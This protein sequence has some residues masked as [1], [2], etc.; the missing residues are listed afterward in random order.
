M[1]EGGSELAALVR[2]VTQPVEQLG[3]A[4]LVRIDAATPVDCFELFAVRE[5]GDLLRFGLGAM[6]APEVILIK[7]LHLRIDRHDARAGGVKRDGRDLVTFD[8]RFV[9]RHAG[10]GDQGAHLIGVGLRCEIRVLAAAMER[11]VCH[12]R[13]QTPSLAV[14]NRH[15]DRERAKIHTSNNGHLFPSRERFLNC[16]MDIT[17]PDFRRSGTFAEVTQ[18]CL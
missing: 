5:F 1:F 9:D 6:V 16:N 11:I 13:T 3:E 7:V 12:S 18:R 4:P 14:H 17:L 10:G 15:A 8:A 2:I